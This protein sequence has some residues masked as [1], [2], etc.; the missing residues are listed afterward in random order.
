M[1][2]DRLLTILMLLH[3]RGKMTTQTLA[4]ELG[5]SR[6]T[7]LRDVDAL[8]YAGVPIYADGGHGG[9]IALDEHYRVTLTGLNEGEVR[10]LFVSSNAKLLKDV[11]LGDAAESTLLKLFAAL[12]APHQPSVDHIRQR[13]LIDPLWW[14]HDTQPLP[15]WDK[16]Q[17]AVY[18]DRCIRVVYENYQ[19]AVVER[20]LE[21]Y[22]LVAKA[23]LWYLIARREGDLRTYRVSRFHDVILLD[24]HFTRPPD[25]DLPT[26]WQAHAQDFVASASEY[27]F[28]VRMP[29]SRLTLVKWLIPGRWNVLDESEDREWL[30]ARFQVETVDLAKM[31]VFGL[32]AGTT[33]LEP[34]ELREAVLATARGMVEG[35]SVKKPLLHNFHE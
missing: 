26:Y 20:L 1:R 4:G 11:G 6:R 5:V 16:L 22:S 24:A 23:S 7:I 12:P 32:G 18:E 28:T 25:F 29:A 35:I 9:G 19:G 10:A 34:D 31:L 2:A 15:F 33:V 21:P 30:T 17:Q 3:S 13:I 8:S 27:R 14:W